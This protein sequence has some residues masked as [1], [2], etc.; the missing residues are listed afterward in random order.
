[1]SSFSVRLEMSWIGAGEVLAGVAAIVLWWLALRLAGGRK[2]RP[3]TNTRFVI[4]PSLFLLWMVGSF[5][6]IMRGVGLL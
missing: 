6:L 5:M 3:L 2:G 1:M 4:L